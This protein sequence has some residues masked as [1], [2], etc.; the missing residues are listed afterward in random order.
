[1]NTSRHNSYV[2]ELF[3]DVP[4]SIVGHVLRWTHVAHMTGSRHTHECVTSRIRI[5]LFSDTNSLQVGRLRFSRLILYQY[6]TVE[7]PKLPTAIQ[8][9]QSISPHKS[10]IFPSKNH[11]PPAKMW[12]SPQKSPVSSHCHLDSVTPNTSLC[13]RALYLNKNK[14]NFKKWPYISTKEP[15][16]PTK[17]ALYLNSKSHTP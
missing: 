2:R 1:M 9:V 11:M 7:G 13:K 16:M 10:P 5:S 14:K 6:L 3:W 17:R 8:M 15:Y 4:C 12:L